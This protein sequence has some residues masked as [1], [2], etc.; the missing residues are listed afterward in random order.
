MN[1]LHL[2]GFIVAS[3]IAFFAM[4]YCYGQYDNTL[5]RRWKAAGATIGILGSLATAWFFSQF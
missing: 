5:E 2:I 4:L 1:G 3:W